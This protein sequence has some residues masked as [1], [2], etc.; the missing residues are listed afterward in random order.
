MAFDLVIF[1]MD[2]TL[3]D[4][5]PLSNRVFYDKLCELGL[6]PR[7]DEA[8]VAHDLTGLSL[9]SCFALVR[10]RYGIDLP[11]NF[12]AI[13]QAET[14]RRLRAELKPIPGVPEMLAQ[15][16]HRKCVASSSE[17][18]KIALSLDLCGLAGHFGP[19]CFSAR[20]VARGKPHPDLFLHA[21]EQMGHAPAACAVIEDSLPGATAGI[22]AGMTVFA[23]RPQPQDGRIGDFQA[24]GCHVFSD[25]A[26]LPSLLAGAAGRG[27]GKK[28][29]A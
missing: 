25:M 19:H 3:V 7:F 28:K 18:E 16:G 10:E 21:A 14:Y 15:I 27:A 20:Q 17:L 4:S 5:E 12:E 26:V 24:L 23:Y 9:P 11:E 13:L 1:D 6:D 29:P 2:G 22:R 8:A